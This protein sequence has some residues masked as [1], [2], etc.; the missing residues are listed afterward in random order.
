MNVDV[1]GWKRGRAV[2]FL[3][4]H[5]NVSSFR[6]SAPLDTHRVMVVF[7]WQRVH[8]MFIDTYVM[9]RKKLFSQVKYR[10]VVNCSIRQHTQARM[11]PMPTFPL[12]LLIFFC[13]EDR[14]FAY[15]SLKVE[16]FSTTAK[17]C[18]VVEK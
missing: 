17:K 14:C 4:I 6:Y 1:G 11:L 8:C 7:I 9:R 16:P 3:G 5:A 13:V 18:G 12:Y 15:V 2:S 10:F